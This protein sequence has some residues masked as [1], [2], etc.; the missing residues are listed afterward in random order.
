M[1]YRSFGRHFWRSASQDWTPPSA[2]WRPAQWR[3]I[4]LVG[5]RNPA[6][7]E[8]GAP[9]RLGTPAKYDAGS[10]PG[11]VTAQL[12][13]RVGAVL[14]SVHGR[15]ASTVPAG[16]HDGGGPATPG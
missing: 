11:H 2:R 7:V 10:A 1:V 13:D 6:R 8:H 3:H 4:P 9:A 16:P 14:G 5:V 12:V 15:P